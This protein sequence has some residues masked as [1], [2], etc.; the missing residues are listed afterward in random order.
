MTT[1]E[2][3]LKEILEARKKTGRKLTVAF[4]YRYTPHRARIKELLMQGRIGK[5]TSVDFHWYLDT[6]H[7]ASYF[8]RWHGIRKHSGSLFCTKQRITLTC[9]TGGSIPIR[10]A[11]MHWAASNLRPNNSFRHTH[12]RTC[13]HTSCVSSSR[14]EE[15]SSADVFVCRSRKARYIA[16]ACLWRE[17]IDIFDR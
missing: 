13:P 4:N 2:V 12:Y 1:D 7:G 3:K 5:V 16:D 10:S 8:R 14:H 6:D 11:S 15:G 17:E 9:S